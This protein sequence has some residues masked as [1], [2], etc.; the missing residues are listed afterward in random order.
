MRL[1]LF[2]SFS[3]AAFAI[4]SL[5]PGVAAQP[6][7][8]GAVT[9]EWFGWSH[10]RFTSPTGKI[11][12]TNPFTSN[13]DSPIKPEDIEHAD[14]IVVA[15]GHG[16]EIG[17][18]VQ[19]AQNTGARTF[20]P[21][22]LGTWL[23]EQGVPQTQVVRSN[24]GGRLKLDDITVRMVASEHGSS[25]PAPSQTTPYGGPAAGFFI[26]FENGWTVYFS[27][28]TPLMSEQAVW[29]Q[30]YKPDMAILHMGAD[31]DPLDFA[32]QVKL[33]KTENPNLQTIMPHHNR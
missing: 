12:L 9:M 17:S 14:L 27:G 13:P 4:V 11:I 31:H 1:G 21:F 33:L 8:S 26:T 22:E 24:P 19:I 18:T 7:S 16:D 5:A 29:A 25:L 30:L 32:E 2:A 10:F 3:V 20:T 15:D 6:A 23:T 28:S